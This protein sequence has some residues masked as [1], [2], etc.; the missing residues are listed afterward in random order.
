M[1]NFIEQ[2]AC[3]VITN[4]VSVARSLVCYGNLI[5][6]IIII[7]SLMLFLER[8]S[9]DAFLFPSGFENGHLTKKNRPRTQ[10]K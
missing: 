4:F 6:I 1:I 2:F 9:F 8:C 3:F 7:V 5:L 10:C